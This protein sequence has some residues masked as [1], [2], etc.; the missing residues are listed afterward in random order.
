VESAY[1]SEAVTV[2]DPSPKDIEAVGR[3]WETFMA[4]GITVVSDAVFRLS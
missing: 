3:D 2:I 1:P 4:S